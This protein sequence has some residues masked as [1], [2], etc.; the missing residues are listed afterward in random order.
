M[1]GQSTQRRQHPK[2]ELGAE[3][4]D[5]DNYDVNRESRRR[6]AVDD[7]NFRRRSQPSDLNQDDK[8]LLMQTTFGGEVNPV[9]Y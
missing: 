8:L 4:V 9:T 1:D 7:D 3:T 5:Y 2:K 6:T